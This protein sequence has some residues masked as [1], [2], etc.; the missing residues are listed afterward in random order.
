MKK[1]LTEELKRIH[2]MIYG[3]QIVEQEQFIDNFLKSIGFKKED[4]P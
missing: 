2:T 1:T 4:D 3:Q